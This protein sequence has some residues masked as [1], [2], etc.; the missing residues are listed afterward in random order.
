MKLARNW[1]TEILE[2][3]MRGLKEADD[4]IERAQRQLADAIRMRT[5]RL[6]TI[7]RIKADGAARRDDEQNKKLFAQ[8]SSFS[9]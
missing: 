5:F 1:D 3:N 8:N 4:F 2:I 7:A 9:G 6:K